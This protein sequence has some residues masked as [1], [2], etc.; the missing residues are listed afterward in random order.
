[1]LTPTMVVG[2][3]STLT[4]A[5]IMAILNIGHDPRH[6]ISGI[7][8]TLVKMG[9]YLFPR[10][11]LLA[12][13]NIIWVQDEK[14]EMCYKKYLGPDWKADYDEASTV[15]NNHSCFLDPWIHALYR[16][17]CFVMK[18]RDAKNILILA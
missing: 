5:A 4:M 10:I 2:C 6:K 9:N 3:G 1:M 7:R 17:P 15:V 14:V 11:F 8:F 12:A 13:G 16:I 18:A